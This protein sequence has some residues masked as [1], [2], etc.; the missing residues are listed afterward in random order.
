MIKVLWICLCYTLNG[1]FNYCFNVIQFYLF[2][3]AV[4]VP[5]K[6]LAVTAVTDHT[7]K[8][9]YFYVAMLQGL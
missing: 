3:E 7:A 4:P 2:T 8:V 1:W 6:V 5:G 9:L